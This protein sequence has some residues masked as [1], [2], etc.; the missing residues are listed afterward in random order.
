MSNTFPV[1]AIT[2]ASSTDNVQPIIFSSQVTS[3]SVRQ[4][5]I[6][7]QDFSLSSDGCNFSKWIIKQVQVQILRDWDISLAR[8]I[9]TCN[10]DKSDVYL[11]KLPKVNKYRGG[12]YPYLSCEDEIRIYAGY[13][14]IDRSGTAITA[15]DL[16][17][18]VLD[19]DGSLVKSNPDGYLLPIFWGFIDSEEISVSERGIFRILACRDRMRIFQDSRL[20]SLDV[21]S[22]VDLSSEGKRDFETLTGDRVQ[23]LMKIANSI[24]G[25]TLVSPT[26]DE[27]KI[28]WR[29]IIEGLT[30]RGFVKDP[31]KKNSYNRLK[32]V[33]NQ[34]GINVPGLGKDE[35]ITNPSLW[36][37]AATHLPSLPGGQ[38][39]FHIW[40]ERPP[41]TKGFSKGVLQVLNKT[42]TQLVNH[43]ALT[44]E[45]P[46]DFFVSHVNGDFVF[47][48]RSADFSG[49][50]D[51]NRVYRTYYCLNQTRELTSCHKNEVIEMKAVTSTLGTYNQF[52]ILD[53]SYKNRNKSLLKQTTFALEQY[54]YSLLDRDPMPPC[55]TQIIQDSTLDAWGDKYGASLIVGLNAARR[56]ARDVNA[57]QIKI[58]GDSTW[59]PGEVFQV[60][61]TG[62]HDSETL[63]TYD[64]TAHEESISNFKMKSENTS[65]TDA[66]KKNI[67]RQKKEGTI[68]SL[69]EIQQE[70]IK[71]YLNSGRSVTNIE[72]L[73]ALALPRY[74]ARAVVHDFDRNGFFTTIKGSADY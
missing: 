45:R 57:I 11:P 49:L 72:D 74:K 70:L 55:R 40:A 37:R 35:V 67:E 58:W 23:L 14:P 8:I 38:P 65:I 54:P 4:E 1:I 39:R 9:L 61:N 71:T 46:I 17:D 44:E 73:K 50:Q 18:Y 51:V 20:V 53:S 15:A 22:D 19:K 56:W 21:N 28:C 12:K 29:K 24:T 33:V 64:E 6:E 34:N 26:K 3:T 48:P 25:Q 32:Q 47:G 52:L 31:N 27:V 2:L 16:S 30:I 63:V 41:V 5:T 69:P 7:K 59:Y 62:I 43:L 42:P 66:I 60:W 68:K 13:L 36:L 10:F